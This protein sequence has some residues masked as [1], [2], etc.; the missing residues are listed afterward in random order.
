MRV[1]GKGRPLLRRYCLILSSG[2][3]DFQD[4]QRKTLEKKTI[5]SFDVSEHNVTFTSPGTSD[6]SAMPI[7]NGE[8]CA[9][10]WV[11]ETG[12]H[13]YLSRSDAITELDRTVKLG[14]FSVLLSPNPFHNPDFY[15]Q[16]LDLLS[17][18]VEI[19]AEKNGNSVS[20]TLFIDAAADDLHINA[21][22][23]ESISA[24]LTVTTWRTNERSSF[25]AAPNL[26]G[27]EDPRLL[28]ELAEIN[29][30]ADVVDADEEGVFVVHTN[31]KSI[32]PTISKL[33]E[34]DPIIH[35]VP[36]LIIGRSFGAYLRVEGH[37]P[38]RNNGFDINDSREFHIAVSTFS[39]QVETAPMA[40]NRIRKT[41]ISFR[42]AKI[43]TEEYWHKYWDKSWI[44]VT[45]DRP[46]KRQIT[47]EM[48]RSL[49]PEKLAKLQESASSPITRAYVLTKWMQACGN[50]GNFPIFYNGALFTLMPGGG[51]RLTLDSFG[52]V[53]SSQP[54]DS[55]SVDSNPDER[56]WTVEHLWQNLRLP[57]YSALARG[58]TE[59]FIPLFDY[60]ERF[61]NLNRV[62]ARLHHNA[63]GQWNTEM[64]LSCG[65][66]SPMVYGLDRSVRKPGQA[67]NRW[68]GSIDISPGLELVKLMFDYWRFTEDKEF[69]QKRVIPYGIDLL[70]FAKSRFGGSDNPQLVIG[71]INCI[72]TYFDTIDPL[73]IV[74]GYK[75]LIEDLL[76]VANEVDL[77]LGF[78]QNLC[79]SLPDLPTIRVGNQQALA[80]AR[81]YTEERMNVE[82]PEFYAIY[83]FDLTGIPQETLNVTWERSISISECF[84]PTVLGEKVGTPSYSGWQYVGPTAARLGKIEEAVEVLENNVALHNPGFAFPAMWGPIYDSV[85]DTDHGA[86]I[87]NTL[88]EIILSI[89]KKPD[90]A[91]QLPMN[92]EVDFK[93]FMPDGSLSKGSI[94]K[95]KLTL[96][97]R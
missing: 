5:T 20:L 94:S 16:T 30:S 22:S 51:K 75:K 78:L 41:P 19:V 3:F 88:Q 13:F 6:R 64:T 34:L 29:E 43:R 26:W 91:Q 97:H 44:S 33:H 80:P 48:E 69:L 81:I 73:P 23:L 49:N 93:L 52:S 35:N 63:I 62:R 53:F 70:L 86:N 1:F 55:P 17:G 77:D 14:L 57:Y 8:L 10:I 90:L 83:P 31:N 28:P 84:R 85:P 7:G 82:I 79:D 4:V 37:K 95:Q 38:S 89:V 15:K 58:E 2:E 68:G 12:C 71:P 9:S 11:D 87:L 32:V 61:E 46:R 50:R 67:V 24:E 76:S 21:S 25:I 96:E 39:S 72:E 74:A 65:L 54:L 36:D 47:A 40:I 27:E 56:T 60:F 66:Q 92:W 59:C 18:Q 42:N 45:G